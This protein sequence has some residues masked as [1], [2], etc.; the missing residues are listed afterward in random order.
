MFKIKE[1][2]TDRKQVIERQMTKREHTLT[3]LQK[4]LGVIE[5]MRSL[6]T[7]EVSFTDRNTFFNLLVTHTLSHAPCGAQASCGLI[8]APYVK[9]SGLS[10]CVCALAW[11]TCDW[12]GVELLRQKTLGG[13]TK[14][15]VC[16]TWVSVSGWDIF[17]HKKKEEEK[18]AYD[19]VRTGKC[20][21]MCVCVQ[22]NT[23]RRKKAI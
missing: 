11:C 12:R 8:R 6:H 19:H 10:M 23:S 1:P 21:C 9:T 20:V 13:R 3:H 18:C 17:L 22:N 15:E 16:D 14:R 2:Q 4:Y 5:N 7:L